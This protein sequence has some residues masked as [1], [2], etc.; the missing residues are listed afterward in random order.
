LVCSIFK[1][2]N[3]KTKLLLEIRNILISEAG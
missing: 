1:I 2:D 3:K